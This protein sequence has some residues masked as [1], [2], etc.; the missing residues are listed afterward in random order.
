MGRIG[1]LPFLSFRRPPSLVS[2]QCLRFRPARTDW[3]ICRHVHFY[4][5]AAWGQSV[6]KNIRHV[7]RLIGG[8]WYL[9]RRLPPP[10]TLCPDRS[11]S[12]FDQWFIDRNGDS[13]CGPSL[14]GGQENAFR[15][16]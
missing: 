4:P 2:R 9:C 13:R 1:Y 11:I 14:A 5:L 12:L 10:N 15:T 8:T 16:R 6:A 3:N 7:V